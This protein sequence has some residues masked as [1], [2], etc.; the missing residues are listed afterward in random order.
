M[1]LKIKK[2][3]EHCILQ[4]HFASWEGH[5]EI[6][7]LL[8]EKGAK[9]NIKDQYNETPLHYAIKNNHLEVINF[10][11]YSQFLIKFL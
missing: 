1:K 5:L 4:L 6:V 9:I 3:R 10:I 7:K 2:V 11:E 8:L